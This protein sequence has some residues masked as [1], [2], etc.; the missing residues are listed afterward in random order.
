MT[1]ND[2]ALLFHFHDERKYKTENTG[3]NFSNSFQDVFNPAETWEC[4]V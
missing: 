3:K 1:A 4:P 2:I